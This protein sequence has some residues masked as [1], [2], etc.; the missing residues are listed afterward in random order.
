[1][2]NLIP[3]LTRVK[4]RQQYNSCFHKSNNLRS[5]SRFFVLIFLSS[6][7]MTF[8]YF[9]A[10]QGLLEFTKQENPLFSLDDII[11]I[12]ISM[13]IV[14][15]FLSNIIVA[16][17]TLYLSDSLEQIIA[18]PIKLNTFF[19]SKLIQILYS[20]S[21]IAI[22]FT[23]PLL[24]AAGQYYSAN[25][26]YYIIA[27]LVSIP[28]LLLP[29]CLALILAVIGARFISVDKLRFIC[30]IVALTLIL[31]LLVSSRNVDNVSLI[32]K[33]DSIFL[34]YIEEQKDSI[35]S[36]SFI[37]SL[38]VNSLFSRKI[39]FYSLALFYFLTFNAYFISY[40]L[41][42]FLY[43]KGFNNAI[44]NSS[45]RNIKSFESQKF[46][47]F[48]TPFI[49]SQR[50][51]FFIKEF[52]LFCRDVAQSIQ[53]LILLGLCLMY[54]I[55]LKKIDLSGLQGNE[56]IWS[57][58]LL[59]I[60][61]MG[62][63]G[64]IICALCTRFVYTS[65]SLEGK[66]YWMILKA[67][68]SV[69]KFINTKFVFWFFTISIVSVTVY[70]SG[71]LALFTD[72]LIILLQ[73]FFALSVTF[74]L[75]GLAIGFGIFFVH[76]DWEHAAQLATNVGSILFMLTSSILLVVSMLPYIILICIYTLR[77]HYNLEFSQLQWG[78][79]FFL[80][81]FLVFFINYCIARWCFKKGERLLKLYM[82]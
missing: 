49:T 78:M 79:F 33:P 19:N 32:T 36:V 10:R 66:S 21:W 50:R 51:A 60:L 64:F 70:V 71:A 54:L 77:L 59:T 25:F 46:L 37:S 29:A 56:Y 82:I 26:Y 8:A 57:Q 6:I 53:F 7:I 67:P 4:L 55:N 45:K 65:I 15:L 14:M 2:I 43:F 52:K 68:I 69:E 44:S 12:F 27:L 28:I 5:K 41:F 76:F 22:V 73:L 31:A 40:F 16:L 42:K 35:K 34:D 80:T 1:M 17:T 48:I 47:T 72:P 3:L 81:V 18:S 13:I 20:S 63:S 11:S 24:V 61:H 9:S 58:C 38:I 23:A 75:V 30:L 39:N 74:G 62:M